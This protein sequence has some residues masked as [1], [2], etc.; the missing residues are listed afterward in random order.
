MILKSYVLAQIE[1]GSILWV[2]RLICV[3]LLM[4]EVVNVLRIVNIVHSQLIIIQI[5]RYMISLNKKK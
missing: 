4:D 2:R 3:Q 1:L 5:A